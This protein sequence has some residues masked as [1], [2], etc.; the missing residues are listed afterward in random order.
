MKSWFTKVSTSLV[1]LSTCG[2]LNSCRLFG[3]GKYASQTEVETDVPESLEQGKPSAGPAAGEAELV[4]TPSAN[5]VPPSSNLID[6]PEP[7]SPYGQ[8]PPLPGTNTTTT[9][10]GASLVG[11]PS[12]GRRDLIDIPKPDFG[13]VSVHTTRPPAEMLSLASPIPP[14][15]RMSMDKSTGP[16]T[17]RVVK[18]DV[19]PLTPP[20]PTESEIASAP[21]ASKVEP[22]IPAEPG[23]PLLLGGEK[24]SDFY[25]GLHQP[26]L[27][28]AVVE[29]TP[30]ADG[31]TPTVEPPA[32]P[33]A[34]E[35]LTV[36]PPPPAE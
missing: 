8:L 7:G 35:T 15:S 3:G 36:P 21:K 30:P 11:M 10:G 29:N 22:A 2:A 34:D 26:L 13:N 33:P 6:I 9:T 5:G 32:P 18:E 25:A 17:A 23:V 14:G 24:L 12:D 31:T 27:D 16:Y 28:G 19:Q 20:G 4:S 1:L